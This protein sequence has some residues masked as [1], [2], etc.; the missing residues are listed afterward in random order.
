MISRTICVAC[1]GDTVAMQWVTDGRQ[2]W[3]NF[4]LLTS[5][6]QSLSGSLRDLLLQFAQR[7]AIEGCFCIHMHF[8]VGYLQGAKVTRTLLNGLRKAAA[9]MPV[10]TL[11]IAIVTVL[12]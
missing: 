3:S 7:P 9:R 6:C 12:S 1:G 4:M 8:P 5:E 2:P 11:E 10:E